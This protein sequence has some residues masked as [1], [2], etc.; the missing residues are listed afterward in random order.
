MRFTATMFLGVSVITFCAVFL[1]FTIQAY[2][3][4]NKSKTCTTIEEDIQHLEIIL[5]EKGGA[6]GKVW[7]WTDKGYAISFAASPI[8]KKGHV[9]LSFYDGRGCLTRHPGTGALRTTLPL[10]DKI[11]AYIARSKLY[12][13]N[14][15]EILLKSAGYAI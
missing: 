12:W 8:F 14:T 11:K 5:K 4:H 9:I 3:H 6:M 7:L 2:P 1:L 10:T 15:D 13:K